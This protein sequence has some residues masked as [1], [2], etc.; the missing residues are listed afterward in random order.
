M[1]VT[2]PSAEFTKNYN[3]IK[4]LDLIAEY[5]AGVEQC[6]GKTVAAIF[7]LT[8]VGKST[9]IN[10]LAHGALEQNTQRWGVCEY[11]VPGGVPKEKQAEMGTGTV[12]CTKA[13]KCFTLGGDGGYEVLLLDTRGLFDERDPNE[14]VASSI[15]TQAAL[16]HAAHIKLVFL[17]RCEGFFE[18]H[19]GMMTFG[20]PFGRF[21][22]SNDIPALFL[23][24]KFPSK[25]MPA[26]IDT[27]VEKLKYINDEMI[28]KMADT[29]VEKD[30]Q[31]KEAIA[32]IIKRILSKPNCPVA[33]LKAKY[34][35]DQIIK[36]MLGA[37][38]LSSITSEQQ[39]LETLDQLVKDDP[40]FL[41]EQKK[42]LYID[43]MS[44]A[45]RQTVT[46]RPASPTGSPTAARH[47][48]PAAK[49]PTPTGSPTAARH[50]SPAA[51]PPSPTGLRAS[52]IGGRFV[53]YIDPTDQRSIEGIRVKIR[54]LPNVSAGLLD[55]RFYGKQTQ[56]FFEYF[57]SNMKKFTA[58]IEARQ[59][60][61]PYTRLAVTQLLSKLRTCVTEYRSDLRELQA[62]GAEVERNLLAKYDGERNKR[63]TQLRSRRVSIPIRIKKIEMQIADLEAAPSTQIGVPDEWNL[64]GY[65]PRYPVEFK[66]PNPFTRK[67]EYSEGTTRV[68]HIE[69]PNHYFVTFKAGSRV[70][71]LFWLVCDKVRTKGKVTFY[72]PPKE[73][74]ENKAFIAESQT[75]LEG[76]RADLNSVVKELEEMEKET[77]ESLPATIQRIIEQ[78][79]VAEEIMHE[80]L[81]FLSM[82]EDL[83]KKF[84][85]RRGAKP[86][87]LEMYYNVAK[88]L[89]SENK[90]KQIVVV[91]KFMSSYEALQQP[92]KP[93][94]DF[95]FADL[96]I[97]R[98]EMAQLKTFFKED[99]AK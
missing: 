53:G 74:P 6:K 83:C 38:S 40:E 20:T 48:P 33:E 77:K 93:I 90:R 70:R 39:M 55:F 63:L 84:T 30:Q 79:A 13:P 96:E 60:T 23:F 14:M 1:S 86:G 31:M 24:N 17:Q 59:K 61:R 42:M 41:E 69:K 44:K 15:L 85:E 65:Y 52:E 2:G 18:G 16:Y 87:V 72:A 89:Y 5:C 49:P 32:R 10:A 4:V 36:M 56:Q 68:S 88:I 9:A 64:E 19:V 35:V 11:K 22:K 71:Q 25:L 66:S 57:I 50:Q 78:A 67:E 58:L 99:L 26:G 8:Q 94:S 34:T 37:V 76:L 73:I 7:G 45:F 29:E 75:V 98:R 27:T 51:Q 3:V 92:V 46:L 47:Q 97:D 28:K 82:T 21:I 81:Q 54:N 62:R 91:D 12:G 80:Y 43:A 95:E